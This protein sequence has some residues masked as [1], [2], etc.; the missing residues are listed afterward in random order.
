MNLLSDV[1]A[2]RFTLAGLMKYGYAVYDEIADFITPHI[3]TDPTNQAIYKCIQDIMDE[4]CSSIDAPT[5]LVKAGD[6]RFDFLKNKHE[7][8][9]IKAIMETPVNVGTGPKMATRIYK[10]HVRSKLTELMDTIK[11]SLLEG[12]N[13]LSIMEILGLVEDPIFDFSSMLNESNGDYG[14]ISDGLDDWFDDIVNNPR[15]IVGISS[16]L[17]AYDKAIG[18]G[19]RR[20]AISLIGARTKTG[21][22]LL[23]QYFALHAA[24][25]GIPVLLVDTEMDRPDI[26]PRIIASLSGIPIER[27]ETG[28][29][30]K[31]EQLLNE[32]RKVRDKIKS[33]PITYLA[34]KER[35]HQDKLSFMRRW[36]R[37]EVG[38]D[39]YGRVK[40]CLIIYDYLKLVDADG[41]SNALQEYQKLGFEMGALHNFANRFDVPI[42]T[43]SQL[44]RDGIESESTATISGSDRIAWLCSNF[45]IFKL[46]SDDELEQDGPEAGNRKLYTVISRHG[47]AMDFG[48]YLNITVQGKIAKIVPGKRK[49]ETLG[50][51]SD[52]KEDIKF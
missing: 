34:A 37:Q 52:S 39:E 31:S 21:K 1:A 16:G 20:R 49:M 22:S 2:E 26:W 43:F 24:E 30:A 48:D 10:L 27:V 33:L 41:L 7:M 9:H 28:K 42:V 36:V 40:D 44:N 35:S 25:N 23:A 46:K 3:F 45:S 13:S 5:L 38:Y 6:L 17:E 19:F 11:E 51:K 14:H 50:F 47:P 29:F 18:G 32:A 12:D 4:S 8:N 15:E